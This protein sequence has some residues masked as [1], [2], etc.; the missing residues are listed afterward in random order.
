M[1]TIS[2][3]AG[4]KFISTAMRLEMKGR[5]KRNREI[6]FSMIKEGY[7][8]KEIMKLTGLTQEQIDYLRSL[9]EF[10]LDNDL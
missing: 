10:E 8:D 1:R 5:E 9:K 4:E 3:N 6:A 2:P 7:T